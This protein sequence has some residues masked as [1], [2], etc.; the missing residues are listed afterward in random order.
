MKKFVPLIIAAILINTLCIYAQND[1]TDPIEKR[2]EISGRLDSL[3]LEK[4]K[5]KRSGKSIKE[6]DKLSALLRDSIE[7]LREDMPI[8]TEDDAKKSATVSKMG[9]S[10]FKSKSLFDWLIIGA[11]A[12]A[13]LSGIVLI[14]GLL[15]SLKKNKKRSSPDKTLSQKM[16]ANRN[17]LL[18]IPI[19]KGK[20]VNLPKEA[21]KQDMESINKLREKIQSAQPAS[22]ASPFDR[23]INTTPTM[24]PSATNAPAPT[25]RPNVNQTSSQPRDIKTEIINA[26]SRGMSEAEIAKLFKISVDQVSLVLKMSDGT[27]RGA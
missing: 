25:P 24:P 10:F 7:L 6:L 26:A 17:G 19:T 12:A 2:L 5:L 27:M 9:S 4:Q 20:P 18:D 15:S 21:P 14:L 23:Q 8:L 22:S 13:L 11:G 16:S 1:L 3:E